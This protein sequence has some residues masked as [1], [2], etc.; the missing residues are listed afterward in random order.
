MFTSLALEHCNLS[1]AR[2]MH[3]ACSRDGASY[4]RLVRP[5]PLMTDEQCIAKCQA[6]GFWGHAPLGNF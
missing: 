5:L 2:A 3:T 6:M 1:V 4:F